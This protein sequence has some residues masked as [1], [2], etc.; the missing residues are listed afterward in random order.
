M[1]SIRFYVGLL[2]ILL[3]LSLLTACKGGDT[4]DTTTD[5]ATSETTAVVTEAPTVEDTTVVVETEPETVPETQP[6]TEP[7]T[8]PETEAETLP[9]TEA[10]TAAPTELTADE[11]KAILSAAITLANDTDD[12]MGTME[13]FMNDEKYA[14]EY[15]VQKGGDF[16]AE[17]GDETYMERIT[18]IGDRAYYYLVMDD[19]ASKT[20]LRYVMTVT[21][22]EREAL[23][24]L[25][26]GDDSSDDGMEEFILNS[27]ISGVRYADGTVEMVCSDLDAT[28]L[29]I[30]FGE[31]VDGM[32]LEFAFTIDS[33][34]RMTL[35]SFSIT[36]PAE[37]TGGE[38][39]VVRSDMHVSYDPE[40]ITAPEDADK[41]AEITYAELF[42]EDVPELPE[43]D[44]E[45][46]ASVGLP[47][48]SD[49]YTMGGEDSAYDLTEQYVYLYFYAPYYEGKTFT[50]YGNV[51][52]DSEGNLVLSF[53]DDIGFVVYFDGISAPTVGSYV[54]LTAT[55]EKT[56]DMGDY[57]DF[58]CFTM[59]VTECEVLG[60]AK[61]PNGGKLMYVTA[62]SLNVR[63][64]PD[65]SQ[66]NK[67]GLLSNGDMVEVLETGFG[68]GNWVKITF[69]CDAGYA[70]VS[71]KYLSEERP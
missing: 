4:P 57:V 32:K 59:M 38:D 41:Y 47:L 34:G 30:L 39:V 54:K 44:P 24:T 3:S 18:V 10:E 11:L 28:L 61:G 35:A 20:T 19:G 12:Y 53:G 66:D 63:S 8:Q 16:M 60:E 62:S 51:L 17:S 56:V 58:E 68:D 29:E 33:E 67:V 26:V 36:V 13:A 27:T 42:G 46:A 21:D 6:E 7:E 1:K 43:A 69:D 55:F 9:E 64:E 22:E 5:T 25:Y 2:A 31:A 45:E 65:S 52:E 70:Y 48:D 23:Y 71:G 37:L 15:T 40:D 50:L 49:S 14:S